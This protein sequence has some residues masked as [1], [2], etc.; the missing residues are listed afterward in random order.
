M[1][2]QLLDEPFISNPRSLFIQ[3]DQSDN[4]R[5]LYSSE[6]GIIINLVINAYIYKETLDINLSDK[7]GE[8]KTEALI[9]VL[10]TNTKL[11]E[12]QLL[13]EL[14]NLAIISK[15]LKGKIRY[16]FSS[17]PFDEKIKA[18][19]LDDYLANRDICFLFKAIS[20]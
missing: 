18:L 1:I 20:I 6:V 17:L 13:R 16:E 7:R 4:K 5:T 14:Y 10:E 12:S 15:T 19:K 9:E 2:S 8:D 3:S 11:L